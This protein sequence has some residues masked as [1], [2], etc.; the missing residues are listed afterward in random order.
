MKLLVCLSFLLLTFT[1]DAN[2]VGRLFSA[3][4]AHD[5]NSEF[6]NVLFV[7]QVNF[8]AHTLTTVQA[9]HASIMGHAVLIITVTNVYAK[10]DTLEII[11]RQR[12][13]N[14]IAC[15]ARMV[16]NV[17]TKITDI[18]ANAHQVGPVINYLLF[19]VSK[20]HGKD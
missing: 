5:L 18:D 1:T 8:V 14:A 12:S 6:Y 17:L 7:F 19:F 10:M 16:D 9:L 3:I 4:L 20:L 2:P 15:H 11:V 13:M